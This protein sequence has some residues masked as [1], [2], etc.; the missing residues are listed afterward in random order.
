VPFKKSSLCSFGRFGTGRRDLF[1]SLGKIDVA[2]LI[3]SNEVPKVDQV[4]SLDRSR[5]PS[6]AMLH[7]A[8]T[9]IA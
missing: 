3:E 1:R 6:E 4:R 2:T 5:S 7:F 9:N 8:S